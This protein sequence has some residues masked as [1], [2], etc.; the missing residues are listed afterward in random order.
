MRDTIGEWA[1][2]GMAHRIRAFDWRGARL[3]AIEAWPQSVR[4]ACDMMLGC[5]FPA[6][7][8]FGTETV[9]LYNDAYAALLNGR[10]DL[11]SAGLGAL[12]PARSVLAPALK[13]AWNGQTVTLE[14]RLLPLRQE[15]ATENG[16]FTLS[17]SPVRDESSEVRAI[18]LILVET[19]ERVR[20]SKARDFMIAELQHRVRNIL[21]II[22]SIVS[23][24]AETSETV[25]GYVGSPGWSH[26][27]A[28]ADAGAADPQ[29][30]RGRRP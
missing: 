19:S 21:A 12:E 25:E 13:E 4:T 3:G 10:D 22:R 17:C 29:P 5:G 8:W 15:S 11:G 24:T 28:G 2:A 6:L 14:D 26:G 20:A 23:R 18:F 1:S 9:T 27:R 16:C 30:R 7:L